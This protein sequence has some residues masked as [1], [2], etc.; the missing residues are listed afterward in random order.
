MSTCS[1]CAQPKHRALTNLSIRQ[2]GEEEFLD[3]PAGAVTDQVPEV[4]AGWLHEQHYIEG[5]GSDAPA[6][7]IQISVQ[8][9]ASPEIA[10]LQ[11]QVSGLGAQAESAAAD[12]AAPTPFLEVS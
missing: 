6:V 4:S 1:V 9:A 12:Q 8:D 3:V 2:G 10:Q 11:E 7:E 5:V